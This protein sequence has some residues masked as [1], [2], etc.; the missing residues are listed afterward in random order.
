MVVIH[1][2]KRLKFFVEK[3]IKSALNFI[4]KMA[5]LRVGYFALPVIVSVYHT[6]L[7]FLLIIK[8]K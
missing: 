2:R 1:G 4:F 5:F 7:V 6:L 3:Q 8:K